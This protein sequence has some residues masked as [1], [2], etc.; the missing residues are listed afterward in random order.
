MGLC[1]RN[2]LIKY[3]TGANSCLQFDMKQYIPHFCCTRQ[4]SSQFFLILKYISYYFHIAYLLFQGIQ[5]FHRNTTLYPGFDWLGASFTFDCNSF[6]FQSVCIYLCN[7]QPELIYESLI[8]WLLLICLL[9]E[10]FY[11]CSITFLQDGIFRYLYEQYKTKFLIQLM[12]I[13]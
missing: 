1:S 2:C 3:L 12:K 5:D 9:Y 10:E 6:H 8:C 13:M 7:I 4:I 11:S